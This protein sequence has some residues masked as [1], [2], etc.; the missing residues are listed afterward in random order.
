MPVYLIVSVP[1][2][3]TELIHELAASS[4]ECGK[5]VD[6]TT[7]GTVVFKYD[8]DKSKEYWNLGRE[9]YKNAVRTASL[10]RM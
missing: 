7:K 8:E 4:L 3:L 10:L 6:D 1:Q 2:C 9:Y 5:T